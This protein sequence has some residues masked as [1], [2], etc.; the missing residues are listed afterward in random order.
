MDRTEPVPGVGEISE[1]R[2]KEIRPLLRK[3]VKI[4]RHH[5][6]EEPY[7]I[8]LFGS[9][10][11]LDSVPTSD[12]DVAIVG[13]DPVKAVVMAQIR[14]EIDHLPTLR[15]IDI[16]DLCCVEDR[17]RTLVESKAERLA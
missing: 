6:P 7:R 16:V 14:E 10:A 1:M 2:E 8:L 5:I 11:T 9:W 15:K 17:F 4:I 3:I 13:P 12:I